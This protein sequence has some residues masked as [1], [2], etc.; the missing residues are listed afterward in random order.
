MVTFICPE[1]TT[2]RLRLDALTKADV[3]GI[4][5]IFSDPEVTRHYDVERFTHQDEADNLIDYFNARVSSG[6]GI[7]WAIRDKAT[8]TFLGSC[9]FNAWNEYDYSAVIGYEIARSYW[10]QGF[11]PEAVAAILDFIFDDEFRF[12]V[13]RVEA[14]ILPQ[15]IPSERMATKL[16]FIKEGTLRGKCYWNGGFHDMNMF[17][18]LRSDWRSKKN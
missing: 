18:L 10:G 3:Q 8:G 6:T 12:Y 14:L 11:A 5:A 13:N 9:G 2:E 7:R 16:G 1:L 15:N 4:F 17:G